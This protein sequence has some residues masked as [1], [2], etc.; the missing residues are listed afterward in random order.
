MT[1][2]RLLSTIKCSPVL[3]AHLLSV[4]SSGGQFKLRSG[5]AVVRMVPLLATPA[6]SNS[7][8]QL[9]GSNTHYHQPSPAWRNFWE[10]S[11]FFIIHYSIIPRY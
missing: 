7:L 5:A 9:P 10:T 1:L 6:A 11:S 2:S 4:L 3:S 8:Q